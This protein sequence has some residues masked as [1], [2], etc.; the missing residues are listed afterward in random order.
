M[1]LFYGFAKH[2][3]KMKSQKLL[4][5]VVAPAGVKNLWHYGRLYLI[6]FLQKRKDSPNLI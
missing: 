2:F 1:K 3:Q 6:L 4:K 5:K